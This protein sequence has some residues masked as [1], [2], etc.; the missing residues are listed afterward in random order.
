MNEEYEND[1]GLVVDFCGAAKL[2]KL[3]KLG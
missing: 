1:G 2:Q 3:Q